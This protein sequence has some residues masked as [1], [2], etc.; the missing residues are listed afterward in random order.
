MRTHGLI[1]S[2]KP[3]PYS[4][5]R[6]RL[7]A[8]IHCPITGL[9]CSSQFP[10]SS[11]HTSPVRCRKGNPMP[12]SDPV[13]EFFARFPDFNYNPDCT[14]P[15]EWRKLRHSIEEQLQRAAIKR[16]QS[17]YS[18]DSSDL[19]AWHKMCRVVGIVPPPPTHEE[20]RMVCGWNPVCE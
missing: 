5:L 15:E 1:G 16:F 13:A 6:P 20:C 3:G 19:A 14:W 9:T 18:F 8:G 17:T 12:K 11:F 10:Y 2:L 4:P 7:F